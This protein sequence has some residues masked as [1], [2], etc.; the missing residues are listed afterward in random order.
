VEHCEVLIVGG[1]PAGSA[2]ARALVAAGF[3]V[4]VM[5]KANFPRDKVCGGWI[6]PQVVEE[7]GL[8]LE[9]YGRGRTLQ[10]I[11][12]FAIGLVGGPTRHV[13]YG[14]A[15]SHAIRRCEFDDYLLRRSGARLRLG[16]AV[17]KIERVSDGW[18]INGDLHARVLVG[19]GGHGCP[20][21]RELGRGAPVADLIAGEEVEYALTAE[22]RASC[23]VASDSPAL[24]FC[25]DLR[26]YAWVVRKGDYVN[27]GL[28]RLGGRGLRE[29][30][31]DFWS[32]LERAGIVSG[33]A[34]VRFKG[35]AYLTYPSSQRGPVTDGALLIGDALGLAD[36][37]SGE[38]I[39]CAIESGLL[40]A[41]SIVAAQGDYRADR[42][43]SY[44]QTIAE[45]FGRRRTEP[46]SSDGMLASARRA[47]GR[48]LLG[49]PSFIRS[50]VLDRWFLHRSAPPVRFAPAPPA[51][52]L[53]RRAA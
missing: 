30:V 41:R 48:W 33:P 15:V 31:R 2:C 11:T 13:D 43:A 6:I 19:A 10:P 14:R 25:R 39:R 49:R 34:R 29:H 21:A 36:E 9:E 17:E 27:I 20:V 53:A 51:P 8:D 24:Y 26:G 1:G 16:E 52:A 23:P 3:D 44:A 40:A 35:H 18:R 12:G 22:E 5:D 42:L 28:G 46:E 47:I 50:V 37:R 7:T 45:C 4:C 32:D 38:G